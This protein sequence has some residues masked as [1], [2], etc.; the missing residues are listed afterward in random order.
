MSTVSADYVNNL[1]GQTII[2]F[3]G[4]ILQCNYVRNDSITTFSYSY[5]EWYG[6]DSQNIMP[7]LVLENVESPHHWIMCQWQ[8]SGEAPAEGDLGWFILRNGAHINPMQG[9]TGPNQLG[10]GNTGGYWSWNIGGFYDG[11]ADSTLGTRVF[12]YFGPA[13]LTGRLEYTLQTTETGGS[14]RTF[15][16]NRTVASAGQNNYENAVTCGVIYEIS[17]DGSY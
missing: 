6:N 12:T 17:N 11:N 2:P 1:S 16:L 13:Q 3:R 8:I 14:D 5:R 10:G 15:Y 9:A 4:N 7:A